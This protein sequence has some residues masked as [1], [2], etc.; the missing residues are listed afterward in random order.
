MEFDAKEVYERLTALES[1]EKSLHKRVDHIEELV[2]SVQKMTVELQHMREDINRLGE[3]VEDIEQ[4]PAKRWE[5]VIAAIIG[6]FAGG[7]ATMLIS[8]FLGG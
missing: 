2:E 4:K 1:S 7:G 6:A 5:S 8:R 3:K